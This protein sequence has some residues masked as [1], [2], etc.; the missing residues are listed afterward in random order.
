MEKPLALLYKL[1]GLKPP[2]SIVQQPTTPPLVKPPV[3]GNPSIAGP[4]VITPPTVKTLRDSSIIFGC[5]AKEDLIAKD[6][7]YKA[8]LPKQFR[9]VTPENA[10]KWRHIHPQ[11]NKWR[12]TDLDRLISYANA[13]DLRVHGN[14][15]FWGK[16]VPDYIKKLTDSKQVAQLMKDHISGMVDRFGKDIRTWDVI[17]EPLGD[18]GKLKS[19]FFYDMFGD[20]LIPMV[21]DYARHSDPTASLFLSEYGLETSSMRTPGLIKLLDE[22]RK[23]G[24]PIH[25][26]SSQ[27]HTVARLDLKTY[28]ATLKKFAATGLKFHISELDIR[29]GHGQSDYTVKNADGKIIELFPFTPELKELSAATYA[30]IV[31]GYKTNIPKAQQYGITVWAATHRQNFINHPHARDYPAIFANDYTPEPAY[32]AIL[33]LD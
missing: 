10:A 11:A 4:L 2:V 26:I 33:D 17:N 31:S 3:I 13:N 27:M 28:N 8:F 22:W 5:A 30:G 32:Y 9:S 6:A 14:C 19:T 23:E 20:D 15:F 21:F 12:T 1:L 18:N 24:V 25:G 7:V 16:G 29:V